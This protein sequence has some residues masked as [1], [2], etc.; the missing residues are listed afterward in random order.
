MGLF[1]DVLTCE[2]TRVRVYGLGLG[3]GV[4]GLEF[5][6]FRV[7]IQGLGFGLQGLGLRVEGGGLRVEC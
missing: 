2:N 5:E 3:F 1:S 4:R 6:D 7:G